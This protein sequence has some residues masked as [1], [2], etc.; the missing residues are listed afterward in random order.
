MEIPPLH[1]DGVEDLRRGC[2][3]HQRGVPQH[4]GSLCP[5][6]TCPP[7]SSELA[8]FTVHEASSGMW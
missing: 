7:P 4:A 5:N 6:P 1:L 3:A 2:S 8:R